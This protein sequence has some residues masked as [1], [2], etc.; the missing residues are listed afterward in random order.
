MNQFQN[1]KQIHFVGIKGVAMTAL[2]I[3]CKQRGMTVTGSDTAEEFPTDMEL[4]RAHITVSDFSDDNIVKIKPDAVVYT[5]AHHGRENPEVKKAIDMGI[6]V[7]PHGQALGMVMDG[8]IQ[9]SVA[10]SHG[11]TTTSSMIATIL[12]ANEKNPSWAIGCGEVLGLGLSGHFGKGKIF[13]AEAD[14]YVTD[15]GHDSTPRFLWQKPEILVVTNI[16]FDHPDVYQN[17]EAVSDA[18]VALQKQ[19][20][21]TI[22]NI[23]DDNS[24]QLLDGANVTRVGFSPRA[25]F[26]IMHVG[27]GAERTFFVLKQKGMHIGEFSLKVPGRH[28]AL[29]AAQAGVTCFLLG[30]TWEQIRNGLLAFGGAKRRFEKIGHFNNAIVYDDYGHH[31]AEILA[32][33]AAARE[34][35]PKQ[36]IIVVFQ[37]HTYSR[38]KAL[39]TEF[40]GAFQ[41][42]D[43]VILADIYASAREKSG[44][45]TTTILVEETTKRHKNVLYGKDFT[46]VKKILEKDANDGDI[47]IFMGAGDIYHWSHRFIHF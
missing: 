21:Q 9:I 2:A 28:N 6:S 31:P 8:S 44:D 18:F 16:D 37:P 39:L 15:P 23:D 32:T 27:F 43:E 35:Y 19:S 11:K 33:L 13:V 24:K 10:G 12:S 45:I 41:N 47:I 30:L 1:V 36:K 4:T 17:L 22:V 20:R 34:W 46:E 42:A 5:G 26:Q 25:E 3:Y 40:A 29:N 14:E 7:Y 38:T